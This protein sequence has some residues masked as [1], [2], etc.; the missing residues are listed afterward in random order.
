MCCASHGPNVCVLP[1][2][3]TLTLYPPV[4][5]YQEVDTWG[6]LGSH[7]DVR[8]EPPCMGHLPPPPP[9]VLCPVKMHQEASCL[10]S[11][12]DHLPGTGAGWP[13]IS[14][15][16]SPGGTFG[17]IHGRTPTHHGHSQ[18][19]ISPFWACA[20]MGL[21][22]CAT[23]HVS[24]NHVTASPFWVYCV[25]RVDKPAPHLRQSCYISSSLWLDLESWGKS[26]FALE[27]SLSLRKL[28]PPVWEIWVKTGCF[29]W[30]FKFLA[31]QI[32]SCGV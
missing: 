28:K 24:Q 22:E 14:V 19:M 13:L 16:Q 11:R 25:V 23:L 7:E 8:A 9:R 29:H 5:W 4:W 10:Q 21:D 15:F 32:L 2:S 26:N 27:M 3:H 12:K 18:P 6:P 31:P 1:K 30:V 20:P 17:A